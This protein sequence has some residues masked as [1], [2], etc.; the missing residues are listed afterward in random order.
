MTT[1]MVPVISF[2]LSLSARE[3]LVRHENDPQAF[4]GARSVRIVRICGERCRAREVAGAIAMIK[5]CRPAIVLRDS[6]RQALEQFSLQ[7]RQAA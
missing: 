1:R 4:I 6:H 3:R 5:R 2:R 7:F